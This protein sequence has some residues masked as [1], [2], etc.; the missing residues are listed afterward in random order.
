MD[1]WED[2][3]D[4]TGLVSEFTLKILIVSWKVVNSQFWNQGK[5]HK[6]CSNEGCQLEEFS[7]NDYILQFEKSPDPGI[8]IKYCSSDFI[9]QA[10]EWINENVISIYFYIATAWSKWISRSKWSK[11][12]KLSN[13]IFPLC[14]IPTWM[15]PS[16]WEIN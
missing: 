13:Q 11:S 2:E 4:R 7:I 15:S 10:F 5:L 12:L 6:E 14:K 3:L 8:I 16:N 9:F 1:E